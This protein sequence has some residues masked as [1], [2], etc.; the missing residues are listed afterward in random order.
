MLRAAGRRHGF[1]ADPRVE[2]GH[3]R[4]RAARLTTS[5]GV[6]GGS[7]LG[8]GDT[9]SPISAQRAI[10]PFSGRSITPRRIGTHCGGKSCRTRA[11]G[12]I[13]EVR[14]PVGGGA[15]HVV[16]DEQRPVARGALGA[17]PGLTQ[18]DGSFQSPGT[19]FQSTHV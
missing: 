3:A 8:I 17:A 15:R 4:P 11:G 14:E 12:A 5:S 16:Q 10:S 7:R 6:S 1:A 9:A 2:D 13:E 18:P 19:A